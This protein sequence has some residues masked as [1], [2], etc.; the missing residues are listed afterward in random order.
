MDKGAP[1]PQP[2]G[3]TSGWRSWLWASGWSSASHHSQ[4]E[5]EPERMGGIILSLYVTLIFNKIKKLV[6]KIRNTSQE[7][8]TLGSNL[9]SYSF[10]H[11]NYDA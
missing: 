1:R 10:E 5:H 2:P 3:G 8:G 9:G 7:S 4:V 6:F 11:L